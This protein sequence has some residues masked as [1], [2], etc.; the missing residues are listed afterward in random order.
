[1]LLLQLYIRVKG[2]VM[3]QKREKLSSRIG[4][5][6]LS[7]GCAIGLGNIWRFPYV[8]G[9]YGGGAFVLQKAFRYWNQK[10]KNGIY[11]PIWPCWEIIFWSCFIQPSLDGCWHIL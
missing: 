10:V 4:F 2:E 3:E 9:K 1:M 11:F 8:T 5:I 7:A 6:F